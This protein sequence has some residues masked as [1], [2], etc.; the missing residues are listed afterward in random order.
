MQPVLG[1]GDYA[2]LMLPAERDDLIARR[3][4]VGAVVR[5]TADRSRRL[6][7]HR[8]PHP[9]SPCGATHRYP[10]GRPPGAFASGTSGGEDWSSVAAAPELLRT[11]LVTTVRSVAVTPG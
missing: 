6:R 11:G 8:R 9:R 5:P 10:G 3:T 1:C 4:V 7:P 2:R